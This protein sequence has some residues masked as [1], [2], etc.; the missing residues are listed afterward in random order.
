MSKTLHVPDEL[1]FVAALALAVE[2][3][4]AISLLMEIG[5][6]KDRDLS[7]VR[8]VREALDPAY[9]LAGERKDWD[10]SH[11][12]SVL[13]MA[14]AQPD[15][16]AFLAYHM[17]HPQHSSQGNSL[18][19]ALAVVGHSGEYNRRPWTIEAEGIDSFG[20]SSWHVRIFNLLFAIPGRALPMPTQPAAG[21][22]PPACVPGEV[23]C[24][25]LLQGG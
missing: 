1:R 15:H 23:T 19:E 6:L 21:D 11:T 12:I 13:T 2:P 8:R 25:R 7:I 4:D 18:A 10:L 20:V 22:Q 14:L 24:A 3:A 17:A 9:S 16:A 5:A